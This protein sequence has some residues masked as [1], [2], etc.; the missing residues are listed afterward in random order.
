MGRDNEADRV[1]AER[2]TAARKE[3]GDAEAAERKRRSDE[4]KEL[5]EEADWL[6][7]HALAAKAALDYDDIRQVVA[8]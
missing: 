8:G 4:I 2:A 1:A 6:I 7:P 5:A 3:A